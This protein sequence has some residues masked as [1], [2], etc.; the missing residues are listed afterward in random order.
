M[1]GSRWISCKPDFFLTVFVLSKLF[2]RLML[3]KLVAAHQAGLSRLLQC[4]SPKLAHS[5]Q[6]TFFGPTV[7][8]GALRTWLDLQLAPPSRD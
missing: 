5:R 2:R 1:D 4:M 6:A 3:E 7:A 8:N